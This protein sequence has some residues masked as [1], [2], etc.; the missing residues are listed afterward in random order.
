MSLLFHDTIY[1]PIKSRRF[2]YSLG[3]NLLPGQSKI[4]S[5]NCIYCEC[6]W[7]PEKQTEHFTP[8]NKI[9]E[10]LEETLIHIYKNNIPLDVITYAGN[11]EPTLHPDF[12]NISKNVAI[13][14]DL[15]AP[16]K[17][18]VLLTNGTTLEKKA[19]QDAISYVDLPVFKIDSAIEET[20]NKINL[21]YS[22]Y[23]FS[24]YIEAL[25]NFNKP[26]IIQT[27]LLK[28]LI[29]DSVIDNTTNEEIEKL[30]ALYKK[31]DPMYVMLYSL[32]RRPPLSTLQKI[33]HSQMEHIAKQI[34][35]A[36]ICVKWV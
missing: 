11:G 27:M 35:K 32:D 3:I 24:S 17:K 31:I 10:Q 6:G 2:G 34:E 33:E 7:N 21:P 15:H 12:F 26:K 29:N 20:Q 25:L 23:S 14:R 22:S 36:G 16:G 4:C 18:I 1:G 9:L 30:I 8:T 13:L 19:I 5:F 28:G